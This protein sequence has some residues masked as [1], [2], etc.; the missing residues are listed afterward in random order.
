MQ[1]RLDQLLDR[2]ENGDLTRRELLVALAVVLMAIPAPLAAAPVVGTVEQLNCAR[3]D[4]I[5]LQHSAIARHQSIT[6]VN[7]S[8]YTSDSLRRRAR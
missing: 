1:K 2:Y 8:G 5:R 6:S 4:M 7:R 3:D